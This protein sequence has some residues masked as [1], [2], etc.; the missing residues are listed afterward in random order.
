MKKLL[1]ALLLSSTF[2]ACTDDIIDPPIIEPSD[3]MVVT[4]A[5][6]VNDQDITF[7]SGSYTLPSGNEVIP[8]RLAYLLSKFY[9][10]DNDG[11]IVA[12][13]DQYALVDVT[14]GEISF[15]LTDVP[16]G[17]YQSFGFSLGLDSAVNHGD[18]AQYP[19]GHPLS[20]VRNAMHWNWTAGYIF[21]VVEG[22]LSSDLSSYI[23]HVAGDMN[24]V[25]Y[26]IPYSFTKGVG[27]LQADLEFTYEEIFQNPNLFNIETDGKSIH[28]EDDP[29]ATALVQNLA[30]AFSITNIE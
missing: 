5:N 4:I 19:V 6:K 16:Q 21:I 13:E 26:E 12:L 25:D 7:R 8:Y 10:K 9:L 3:D 14:S 28:T 18:P 22:K 27:A 1:I 17:N 23:Y 30:N 29:V 2:L 24:R 15:T 11:N 20:S